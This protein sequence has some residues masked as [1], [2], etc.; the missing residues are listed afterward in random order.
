MRRAALTAS[1]HSEYRGRQLRSFSMFIFFRE[2]RVGHNVEV[3]C[4]ERNR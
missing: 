3:A 1:T 4:H 2:P